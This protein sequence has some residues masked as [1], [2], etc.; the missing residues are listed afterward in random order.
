MAYGKPLYF[1]DNVEYTRLMRVDQ[2]KIRCGS[3]IDK[4]QL[5]LIDDIWY[6]S[7]AYLLPHGGDG[8]SEFNYYVPYGH[9]ITKIEIWHRSAVNALRFTT[10]KGDVSQIFGKNDYPDDK[11]N[12]VYA[13]NNSHLIGLKGK[14]SKILNMVTF[15]W[16]KSELEY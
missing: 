16:L 2:I 1:E 7:K 12:I 15:I 8:G 10:N 4:I 14:S 11:Y 3:H 6:N 5:I 9:Y 13:P